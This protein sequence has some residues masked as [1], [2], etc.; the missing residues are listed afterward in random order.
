VNAAVGCTHALLTVEELKGR[1]TG[2]ISD[3]HSAP[4]RVA[5]HIARVSRERFAW[6][7]VLGGFI[8]RLETCKAKLSIL[9]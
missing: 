9:A 4:L 5:M 2:E 3:G 7:E 1:D 8:R 6:G